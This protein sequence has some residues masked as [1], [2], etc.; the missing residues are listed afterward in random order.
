MVSKFILKQVEDIREQN[1]VVLQELAIIVL[2]L[3][4]V[5]FVA[6]W[7][8]GWW[9]QR[10]GAYMADLHLS[11]E[12]TR[13][14]A[15]QGNVPV[16]T[17]SFCILIF[18]VMYYFQLRNKPKF[19][20]FFI[21]SQI[22]SRPLSQKRILSSFLIIGVSIGLASLAA[23]YEFSVLFQLGHYTTLVHRYT[24][25]SPHNKDVIYPLYPLIVTVCM[26]LLFYFLYRIN[27]ERYERVQRILPMLLF[28]P[29]IL[30]VCVTIER[31]FDDTIVYYAYVFT[32]G[33]HESHL[34]FL[35]RVVT[36][37]NMSV[38][39][40]SSLVLLYLI[41]YCS[42]S[43]REG[44]PAGIEGGLLEG[45]IK[46]AVWVLPEKIRENDSHSVW[47]EL[48]LSENFKKRPSDVNERDPPES[49]LYTSSDY[50]EAELEGV[51]MTVGGQKQLKILEPP[52][53]E[54]PPL[55]VTAWSCSF[56]KHGIHTMNLRLNVVKADKTK[57]LLF[58][59][60]HTVRVDSFLTMSWAPIFAILG[61]ILVVVVQVLLRGGR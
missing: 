52:L 3:Q 58:I 50:L 28:V 61:P 42:N 14:M 31:L 2:V 25:W 9:E 29:I 34:E 4:L 12:D 6:F 47:L 46:E 33:Y 5:H 44:A 17:V 55:L 23:F 43:R 21:G 35:D 53:Q 22:E 1:F 45:V 15:L 48:E 32:T 19:R 24:W 7:F 26:S 56:A 27:H 18:L 30:S 40:A 59:Q 54:T 41:H 20:L 37:G 49:A 13:M 57:Q 39:L 51:G 11:I 16:L 60:D 36:F 38:I 8:A 10:P